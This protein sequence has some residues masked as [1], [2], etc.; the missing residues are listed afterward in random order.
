MISCLIELDF[1][2]TFRMKKILIAM[3]ATVLVVSSILP[4]RSAQ[5][6]TA[7]DLIK[8]S[9]FSSVYFL[10]KDGKRYVFPNE[11]IYYS[12]YTD[13]NDVKNI[14][15]T[16][17]AALPIGDRVM[18]QPG[19]ELVKIPSDPSVFAVE[20]GGILREIPDEQTAISLYGTDWSKRVQ[21]VSEAFWSSVTVG[22]P[23]AENEI[24]EGTVI[25]DLEHNLF[26][27][28]ADG[29]ATEVDTLLTTEQTAILREHAL[30]IQEAED[31]HGEA[32]ELTNTATATT[33]DLSALSSHLETVD[34]EESEEHDVPE[35]TEVNEDTQHG[36]DSNT[37]TDDNTGATDDSSDS[38]SND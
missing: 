36:I 24:P 34:T 25:E 9:N 5:A 18:Y 27:V 20:D 22:A 19:T 32:V 28:E 3:S 1:K 33:G 15:C 16:D 10:A 23:L 4:T 31:H 17:L 35:I 21:D 29:T 11:S 30:S 37:G 2:F 14:S 26:R 12:W 38:S 13:F 8:C 7:G 6:A